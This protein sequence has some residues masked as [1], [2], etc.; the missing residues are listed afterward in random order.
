[1]NPCAGRSYCHFKEGLARVAKPVQ[2]NPNYADILGDRLGP[3]FQK[4]SSAGFSDPLPR[5]EALAV[6][7]RTLLEKRVSI[8][9]LPPGFAV[10]FGKT[11]NNLREFSFLRAF[12]SR[13][14]LDSRI[15]NSGLIRP[16]YQ[17]TRADHSAAFPTIRTGFREFLETHPETSSATL[18][19]LINF[20]HAYLGW[21]ASLRHPDARPRVLVLANDHSPNQVACSMVAKELHIP[22]IYLQHA[23]VTT[24]FPPLDFE[25]SILRNQ[26]SLETYAEAGA[27]SGEAYVVSRESSPFDIAEFAKAL[28]SPAT[29]GVYL[30]AQVDWTGVRHV[31]GQLSLNGDVSSVFIKPHPSQSKERLHQELPG[32]AIEN[33]IPQT[34]HVA[35]VA[36]SSVVIELLHRSIPVFQF[37]GMDTVPDDYYGFSARGLAPQL[38]LGDLRSTFWRSFTPD[39]TWLEEF[40]R[41]APKADT[42]YHAEESR[43]AASL[44][45]YFEPAEAFDALAS[46]V[47]D[48]SDCVARVAQDQGFARTALTIA[49]N[50]VVDLVNQPERYFVGIWS[51]TAQRADFTA[52]MEALFF[53]RSP[54]SHRIFGATRHIRHIGSE[55]VYWVK[56]R[57]IELS[58]R[59]S[60]DHEIDQLGEFAREGASRGSRRRIDMQFLQ[61][62][63]RLRLHDRIEH[64]IE[65]TPSFS[66]RELHV[67][68]RIALMKWLRERLQTQSR[69]GL[70][71][72]DLYEGLSPFHRLKLHVLSATDRLFD[73]DPWAHSDI[74]ARYA[75]TAPSELRSEFERLVKPCYD[76]LRPNFAYM[77][78]RWSTAERDAFFGEV[79]NALQQR[80]P[81]ALLRLSDGEGYIFADG[82]RYFTIADMKNRERHWWREEL[83][84]HARRRLLTEMRAAVGT[85]DVIGIPCIYRFLRDSADTS[86]SLVGTLQG[87]GLLEVLTCVS[88]DPELSLKLFAEEKCNLPLFNDL[89]RIFALCAAAQRVVVVASA[90]REEMER[91]FGAEA[92]LHYIPVPTHSRTIGNGKYISRGGRLPQIYPAIR[93]RIAATVRPGDLVLVAAGV[94]GKIFIGDARRAGG[95]ALDVGSALDEWIDAGIHSLH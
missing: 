15:F 88:A 94:I 24:A 55:F 16:S 20:V 38:A 9:C 54:V 83:A 1:M 18:F 45:R 69:L 47:L 23:E 2:S 28:R 8:H 42:G 52:A 80:K 81:F 65:Q 39:D 34:P 22:R 6:L 46:G 84:E 77:D 12:L 90:T 21:S 19:Q 4:Y 11:K 72:S 29:V 58:G 37:Y 26:A 3:F 48:G 76:R 43:L 5:N 87:R 92:P 41:Y 50:A 33:D 91:L 66:V 30:T 56:Q 51:A 82:S 68:H 40:K 89:N 71:P 10:A 53:E 25:I 60:S 61:L 95:V 67:S 57:D 17:S 14:G 35:V 75:Q 7:D 44:A 85:A 64:F 13:H 78:V 36:N 27:P 73:H 70:I 49:P 79:T 86:R 32:I 74:E 62:L 63:L 93:E 31:L 59:E